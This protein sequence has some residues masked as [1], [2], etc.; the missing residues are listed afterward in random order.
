MAPY[1]RWRA[2][3]RSTPWRS[4]APNSEPTSAKR[5]GDHDEHMSGGLTDG[6]V[7]IDGYPW[8]DVAARRCHDSSDKFANPQ[9]C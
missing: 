5:Y 8:C 9:V 7:K 2:H 4:V 1:S 6:E 3:R